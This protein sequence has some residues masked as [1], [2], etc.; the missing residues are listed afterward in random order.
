MPTYE[1]ECE[2]CKHQFE[3]FQKISDD[4]IKI[5]PFCKEKVRRLISGGCG[6]IFKGDGFP[7]NDI[8]KERERNKD[9]RKYYKEADEVLPGKK[10]RKG[11]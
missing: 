1:Y 5:C 4:P 8:K 10:K 11:K 3:K 9:A 2:K 7:S 6:I